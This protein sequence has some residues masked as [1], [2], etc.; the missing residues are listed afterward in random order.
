MC[1]VLSQLL[2][3]SPLQRSS[4]D[5]W[6]WGT[7]EAATSSATPLGFEVGAQNRLTTPMFPL[8]QRKYYWSSKPSSGLQLINVSW[9]ILKHRQ[10][11]ILEK[12]YS[13]FYD[14]RLNL[15]WTNILFF[16]LS[17]KDTSFSPCPTSEG[18]ILAYMWDQKDSSDVLLEKST[19]RKHYDPSPKTAPGRTYKILSLEMEILWALAYNKINVPSVYQTASKTLLPLRKLYSQTFSSNHTL[20]WCPPPT[21]LT[22]SPWT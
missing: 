5:E 13:L 7:P 1:V 18:A 6:N 16:F 12:A 17:K 3:V 19:G 14:R 2:S 22:L 4:E 10:I 21:M 20:Q 8:F 15:C 9:Y 11:Q